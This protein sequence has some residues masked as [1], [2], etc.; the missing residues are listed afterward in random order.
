M[1]A[2]SFQPIIAMFSERPSHAAKT[3]CQV[4]GANQREAL[5]PASMDSFTSMDRV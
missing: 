1:A 4:M 5:Y 2:K 3:D